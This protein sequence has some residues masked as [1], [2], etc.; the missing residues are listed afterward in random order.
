MAI[1]SPEE[2]EQAREQGVIDA[3]TKELHEWRAHPTTRRV[4][5]FLRA[6]RYLEAQAMMMGHGTTTDINANALTNAESIAKAKMIQ[7]ILGLDAPTLLTIERD[8]ANA[9]YFRV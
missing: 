7:D 1:E 8:I 9:E 2:L 6:F 5:A 3:T 4:F